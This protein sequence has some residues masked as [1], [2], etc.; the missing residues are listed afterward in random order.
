MIY[1]EV[2]ELTDKET[3][4]ME[5]AKDKILNTNWCLKGKTQEKGLRAEELI[6]SLLKL[7]DNVKIMAVKRSSELDEI[8]KVDIVAYDLSDT[9]DVFAFQIKSSLTGA[10]LHYE[11]YGEEIEYQ[12]YY[13]RNPWCLIVDN[14]LTNLELLNLLIDELCLSFNIDINMLQNIRLDLAT[15]LSRRIKKEVIFSN[16][17]TLNKKEIKALKLLFNVSMNSQTFYLKH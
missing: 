13:F 1:K 5:I 9:K 11:Q 14:S 6:C 10:K 4:I 3:K 16:Y 15:S 2:F 8:L 12:D 7:C 17:K